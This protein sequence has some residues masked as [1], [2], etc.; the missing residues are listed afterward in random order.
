MYE[1]LNSIEERAVICIQNLYKWKLFVE[2]KQ[3]YVK[4][5]RILMGEGVNN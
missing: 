2:V 4:Y 5:V 1:D 3:I